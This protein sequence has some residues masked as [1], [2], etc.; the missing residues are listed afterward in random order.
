M[1]GRD[2]DR[3]SNMMAAVGDKCSWQTLERTEGENVDNGG[4]CMSDI[5]NDT[6][7]KQHKCKRKVIQN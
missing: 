3:S 2:V 5:V 1:P 7:M 4:D 6:R